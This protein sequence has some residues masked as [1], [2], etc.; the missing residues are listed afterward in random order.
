MACRGVQVWQAA[1]RAAGYQGPDSGK[2]EPKPKLSENWRHGGRDCT[3]PW[4]LLDFFN[5]LG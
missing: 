2:I 1:A 5:N 3:V 4:K